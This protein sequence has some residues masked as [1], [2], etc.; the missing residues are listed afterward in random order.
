[1]ITAKEAR[2]NVDNASKSVDEKM[3][4]VL[5]MVSSKVES[6]SKEGLTE[7][8]FRTTKIILS[9][10]QCRRLEFQLCRKYGYKTAFVRMRSD[11]AEYNDVLT[12]SVDWS[13][14][15]DEGL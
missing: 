2:E 8:T 7:C 4:D 11:P 10:G 5:D 1:M 13:K 6:A 3:Q 14:W 12:V 15:E 9:E